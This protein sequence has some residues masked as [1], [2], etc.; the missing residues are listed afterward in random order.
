MQGHTKKRPTSV[1]EATVAIIYPGQREQRFVVSAQH[2]NAL[3]TLVATMVRSSPESDNEKTPILNASTPWRTLA[4]KTGHIVADNPLSEVALTVRA[5][6]KALGISQAQLAEKL[7]CQQANVS[8]IEKGKR[9][10]G[11]TMAKKLAKI[12]EVDVR[13]FLV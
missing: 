1:T 10:I 9:S 2:A 11:G 5:Y 3:R 13:M 8:A 7:G 4:I 12:F 6:R